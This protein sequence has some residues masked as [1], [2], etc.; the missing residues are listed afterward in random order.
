MAGQTFTNISNHDHGLDIERDVASR[1]G[2][3]VISGVGSGWGHFV[4]Y[5]CKID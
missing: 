4:S 2:D 5:H 1:D 3:L